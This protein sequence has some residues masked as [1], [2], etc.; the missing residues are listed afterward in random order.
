[1]NRILL[2][3]GG[4]VNAFFVIFHIW[5]GYRIYKSPGFVEGNG[6]LLEMLNTAGVLS[7]LFFAIS[8]LCYAKE[9]LETKLGRLVVLFVFMLYGSRAAEEIFVAS[10]FSPVIFI[11]CTLLALLYLF[12]FL[13]HS[14]TE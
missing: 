4:V 10:K 11:V 9:M 2:R 14:K 13:R 6:P 3:I 5:L 8:S 7:I 1:M 12:L